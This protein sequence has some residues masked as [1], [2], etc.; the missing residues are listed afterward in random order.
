M[1]AFGSG[2]CQTDSFNYTCEMKSLNSRFLEVN[3]RLPRFLAM[4]EPEIVKFLKAK[5]DRGK[6]DLYFDIRSQDI[7]ATLPKVNTAAVAHYMNC[8]Q[9][10]A[11]VTGN[12]NDASGLNVGHLIRLDGVLD[13]EQLNTSSKSQAEMHKESLMKAIAMAAGELIVDRERE[14]QSLYD[15]INEHLVSLRGQ[16]EEV[17]DQAPL[18]R[19]KL[20]DNYYKKIETTK[21]SLL[22]KGQITDADISAER[23]TA[24]LVISSDKTD[25]AEEL[26]R[27]VAHLDEFKSQMDKGD[28]IGRRLD[29]ICQEMHRE[30]NTLSNKLINADIS[31]LSVSMKQNVERIKQQVQNIE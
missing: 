30:I 14:G 17:K 31:K 24:E 16:Y 10:I 12:K 4:L 9:T 3:P 29:F 22:E 6:V 28:K 23:I 18:I 26:D 2:E 21:A 19:A 25:V 27:L 15:S 20:E 5:L 8:A 1:T 11:S 13:S 7:A